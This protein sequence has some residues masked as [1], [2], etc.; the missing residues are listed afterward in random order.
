[1][2]QKQKLPSE[3]K[4]QK[5]T[6]FL[7]KFPLFLRQVVITLNCV[8]ALSTMS[9][10]TT[11]CCGFV[12]GLIKVSRKYF[13]DCTTKSP[14][15]KASH[16]LP[17]TRKITQFSEGKE[18]KP[19][20]KIVYTAGAFDLFRI[21]N[22]KNVGRKCRRRLLVT[23]CC[24]LTLSTK[25]IART[26]L[27]SW[28]DVGHLDFLEQVAKLGDYLIVGLHTDPVSMLESNRKCQHSVNLF[29]YRLL[30]FLCANNLA[31]Y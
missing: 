15:T 10:F 19:G 11:A 23:F 3:W 5:Y 8:G 30:F 27:T 16:F 31:L 28:T 20:D 26:S 2:W 14:W 22:N 24:I 9:S 21:L 25:A 4:V 12:W 18:P 6:V 29:M 17:T 13:Q 1:M 7:R